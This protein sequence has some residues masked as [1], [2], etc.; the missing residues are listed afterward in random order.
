MQASTYFPKVRRML[1]CFSPLILKHF[2]PASALLRG[3]LALATL[4]PPETDPQIV[5]RWGYA[6]EAHLGKSVRANDFGLE[7]MRDVQ[8]RSCILHVGSVSACLSSSVKSMKTSAA[9]YLGIRNPIVVYLMSCTQT[10][11]RCPPAHPD[12]EHLFQCCWTEALPIA[13]PLTIHAVFTTLGGREVF[14]IARR[15]I[16][17]QNG[18]KHELCT[19]DRFPPHPPKKTASLW[20]SHR[21][22]LF[23]TTNHAAVP[24][25]PPRWRTSFSMLLNWS[26]SH[27][28]P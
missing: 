20:S 25:R 18:H 16:L 6:D 21:C 17:D 10:M 24:A 23:T 13:L 14:Q 5:E 12:D 27:R 4:S 26:A 11:Q 15:L 28:T 1:L 7:C 19:Q 9:P 2:W 3:H 8:R 22:A